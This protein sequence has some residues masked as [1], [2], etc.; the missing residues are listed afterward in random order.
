MGWRESLTEET[1]SRGKKKKIKKLKTKEKS[2]RGKSTDGPRCS[3]CGRDPV[4]HQHRESESEQQSRHF[5]LQQN[6]AEEFSLP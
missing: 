1:I 2:P 5:S 6:S 4:V 3:A